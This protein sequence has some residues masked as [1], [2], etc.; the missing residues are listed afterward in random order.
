LFVGCDAV[1]VAAPAQGHSAA[2]SEEEAVKKCI[3]DAFFFWLC[4]IEFREKE[5]SME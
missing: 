5:L 2:P 1:A 3:Y 4:I